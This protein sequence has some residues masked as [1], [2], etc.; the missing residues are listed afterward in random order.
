MRV[1]MRA[2]AAVSVFAGL[3]LV[4]GGCAAGGEPDAAAEKVLVVDSTFALSSIDPARSFEATG[5]MVNHNV[6]E[7]ALTFE[8]SDL[9]ELVPEI[10]TYTI[11]DDNTVV[12]LTLDGEH[13][14]SD[15]TAVTVDDIV[16]SYQRLQGILGNPSFLLDGVTV[17][18]VDDSTVTLTSE[19]SNPQLP[20]IL[21]N[22]AL[23]I[24]QQSVVEE[25]GGTLD[26]SDDA[27]TFLTSESAGSGPY[28]YGTVAVDSSI[29][30][31]KNP[32]YAGDE[33]Y[34][35]R[36][37]INNVG[38]DT[39]RI[40]VEGGQT[41]LAMNISSDEAEQVDD[42]KF[43]VSTGASAATYYLWLNTNDEFG[44]IA[45]DVNF[46]KALRHS[47]NYDDILDVV[48]LGSEQPGGVVPLQFAGSLESDEN[49]TYDV[50]LA[51]ELLADSGYAGETINVLYSSENAFSANV[52][53][54]VQASAAEIGVNIT[55]NPQTAANTLDVFRSG[56]YQ[57]GL[58]NWGAD[59]PDAANYLVFAPGENIGARVAWQYGDGGTADQIAPLVE[60]AAA[61]SGD[62][63]RASAYIAFQEALND[64]GPYIPL[65]QPAS[66][67]VSGEGI[68]GV[69]SNALW[70][71]DFST[72]TGG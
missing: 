19:T 69:E 39:Q 42:S 21:P 4:L 58:A 8:G 55:L 16:F 14:F 72:I 24:L 43:T 60:A 63:E 35:D 41:G 3:S 40:N 38:A 32:S 28:M 50:D 56:E 52:S 61:A 33:P 54:I 15:G 59:Y 31:V 20:F 17:A 68:S 23:S 9:S 7:T 6:Y 12:T 53:Q 26:E 67:L 30:L 25:N 22:P 45:S 49:N 71:V 10:A 13:T 5:T 27:E 66:I 37:V 62:E 48:G 64:Y 65:F 1:K 57:A 29:T 34:Y 47:I 70:D 44:G 11:S 18:K 51:K 36:V 2:T 46:V